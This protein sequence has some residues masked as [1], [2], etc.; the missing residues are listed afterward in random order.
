MS[1][2][3]KP[4][5]PRVAVAS[6]NCSCVD[7]AAPCCVTRVGVPNRIRIL[8]RSVSAPRA[9]PPLKC[10]SAYLTL[11]S[12]SWWNAAPRRAQNW[13]MKACTAASD[14]SVD[15]AAFSSLVIRNCSGPLAHPA[16]A[17]DSC[18]TPGAA[19]AARKA[20]AIKR[21]RI[22][23]NNF[24]EVVFARRNRGSGGLFLVELL[25]LVVQLVHLR[26]D[27]FLFED[28]FAHQQRSQAVQEDAVL[29][30]HLLELIVVLG[31]V[32]VP[33]DV[34]HDFSSFGGAVC[35]TN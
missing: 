34:V 24:S 2:S 7:A 13:S 17:A 25:H 27:F 16:L 5:G 10:S 32:V 1:F 23:M 19:E 31:A 14:V 9:R 20:M 4:V 29:D 26:I 8:P 21:L 6:G 35:I 33:F 18:A 30:D 3:W 11:A 15:H 22:L 12:N 28:A